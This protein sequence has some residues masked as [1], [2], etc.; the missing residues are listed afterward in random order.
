MGSLEPAEAAA[1]LREALDRGAEW[2]ELFCEESKNFTLEYEDGRVERASSGRDAGVGIRVVRGD[3][4]MYAV[5]NQADLGSLKAVAR[6]AAG[7]C[8][9]GSSGTLAAFERRLSVPPFEVKTP[10]GAWAPADKVAL[11]ERAD[12]AAR[13][14]DQHVTRFHGSYREQTRRLAVFNSEGRWVEDER[15]YVRLTLS[16]VAAKNGVAQ[17]GLGTIGMMSG[18]EL[19][20]KSPPEEVGRT[21]AAQAVVNLFASPAPAGPMP[22]VVRPGWGGV[23]FH[24]ASGHALEGDAV[25]RGYSV[26]AG[27]VGEAVASPLV[28]AVDDPTWPGAWGSYLVDDEGEPARPT[29]LIERGVLK[30]YLWDRRNAARA[31]QAS[32]ANGRRQSYQ[33]PPIPRMSNTYIAAG[34]ADPAS[35]IASTRH[36]LYARDLRGG[37][38]NPATGDF[39]FT[40]SEGYLIRDGRADEPVRGA[41]LVGNGLEVLKRVDMI[42]DDLA[43]APGLCGKG[44]QSVPTTVGQPTLRISEIT[45]G[46]TETGRGGERG[47]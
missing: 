19:F 18:V 9:G 23:M 20:E 5:S 21:A 32:T 26:F 27:R 44:G 33:F 4:A 11:L 36:G 14:Y 15:V 45:V 42:G 37:Q 8:A 29:V 31:G 1:V 38:V 22:V 43:V 24:E 47:G 3:R 34:D 30:G 17:T 16:V 2:A 12:R 39:V 46:G 25:V 7:A 28:T 6:D 40:V 10:P 41:T 13:A 35:I